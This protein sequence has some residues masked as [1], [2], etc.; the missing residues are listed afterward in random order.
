VLLALR[1]ADWRVTN[2]ERRLKKHRVIGG[3]QSF[4]FANRGD[5]IDQP[6]PYKAAASDLTPNGQQAPP[7]RMPGEC[8]IGGGRRFCRKRRIRPQTGEK[9]GAS[10]CLGACWGTR[11]NVNAIPNAIPEE[12]QQC[13]GMKVNTDSAMN[14]KRFRQIPER[15]SACPE[16]FPQ[17]AALERS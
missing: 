1:R 13:S 14:P 9:G 8:Q 12:P 7:H 11:A 6:P 17:R 4:Y 15:R 5:P 16:E 10:D 3:C 2:L